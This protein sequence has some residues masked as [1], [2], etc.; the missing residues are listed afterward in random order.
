MVYKLPSLK[1]SYDALEPHFDEETM[2]IHHTKH[3]QTY[4]NNTNNILINT[5]YCNLS[6]QE[7]VSNLNIMVIDNKL[8]LQNNSGGHLNH[9]L[10]WTGLKTNSILNCDFED[11]LKK[12]FGSFES[13]KNAFEQKAMNHFGSGWIWL[14]KRDD[15]TLYIASTINQNNPLMGIKIS[16][17]SG[18]PILGL[19]LWEHAYYLKYKNNRIDY[20][21]SFW[22]VVN[23]DEIST[24]FFEK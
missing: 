3:H 10:F 23:W 21:N 11:V 2:R 12:N 22:N 24:R 4:I 17:V 7:L 20:I 6:I 15:N 1:Y 14:I 8:S 18:K 13:F 9:T 19:D 16:G 5:S